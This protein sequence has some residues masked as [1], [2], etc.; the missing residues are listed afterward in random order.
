M[1]AKEIIKSIYYD[2]PFDE[3]VELKD[4]ILIW[5]DNFGGENSVSINDIACNEKPPWRTHPRREYPPWR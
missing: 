5:I 1:D 3:N 2:L 4:E